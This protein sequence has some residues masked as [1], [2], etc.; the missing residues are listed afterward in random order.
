M[1]RLSFKGMRI[2]GL[3]PLCW[4]VIVC[5]IPW[6]ESMILKELL[7]CSNNFWRELRLESCLLGNESFIFKESG[8]CVTASITVV[9]KHR[10]VRIILRFPFSFYFM[11]LC[12]ISVLSTHMHVW[13][14]V[15]GTHRG[16]KRSGSIKTGV[17]NHLVNAR[18]PHPDSLQKNQV[19]LIAEA[20]IQS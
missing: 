7:L 3:I 20:S 8:L 14:W 1:N 4:S 18:E 9:E 16:Q 13:T 2:L 17:E 11:C 12:V 15:P 5:I 6:E 19:L 10:R